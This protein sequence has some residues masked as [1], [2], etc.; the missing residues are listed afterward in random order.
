VTGI[1]IVCAVVGWFIFEAPTYFLAVGSGWLIFFSALAAAI[2]IH[3]YFTDGA[4]WK[5][6]DPDVRLK[7]FG[8]A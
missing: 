8:R 6:K 5:L 4:I 7:L 2:N 1:F 3:H